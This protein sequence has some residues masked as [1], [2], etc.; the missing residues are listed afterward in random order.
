MNKSAIVA[1]A[2]ER[3]RLNRVTAEGAV[4]SVLEAIAESLRG[5]GSGCA[6]RTGLAA[7]VLAIWLAS[8]AAVAD[9]YYLRGGIGL[10]RPGNRRSDTD[11]SSTAPQRLRRGTGKRPPLP[12]GRESGQVPRV[13]SGL[14]YAP[15]DPHRGAG[16]IR[17]QYTFEAAQF[18]CA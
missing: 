11:C 7:T 18:S 1:R 2:A 16:R 5:R 9:D 4:D 13:E 14:G 17:P 15:G 10:D 3:I 6:H 8:G 12:V